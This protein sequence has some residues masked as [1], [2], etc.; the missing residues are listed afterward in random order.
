MNSSLVADLIRHHS[1][2]A[3]ALE[4][5]IAALTARQLQPNF[6]TE[7]ELDLRRQLHEHRALLRQIQLAAAPTEPGPGAYGWGAAAA[8]LL[9]SATCGMVRA[10]A[11]SITRDRVGLGLRP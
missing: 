4:R 3:G 2:A 7:E 8:A 9:P 1:A 6:R 10:L 11:W 5:R